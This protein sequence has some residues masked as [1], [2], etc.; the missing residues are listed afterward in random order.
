MKILHLENLA[1]VPAILAKAQ[2]ESGHSATVLETHRNPF[3]FPHDLEMYYGGHGILHDIKTIRG[4]SRACL[5]YDLVHVHG[6]INRKRLDVL[7]MHIIHRKPL[8]VHYHGSETRMGY[9]MAYRSLADA[10]IVS[11]PD[12][13]RWHNDAEFIPNPIE[14]VAPIRFDTEATPKVLHVSNNRALKGTDLIVE[15]MKELSS[16]GSNFEFELVENQSNKDVLERMSR[17]HILIDQVLPGTADLPSIIGMVSL[18]AMARGKAVVTTFDHEF[19]QHYP[20]CPAVAIDY[21]KSQ[22]KEAVRNLIADLDQA[23]RL[24]VLGR[25]YISDHHSPKVVCSRVQRVY[26]KVL[27]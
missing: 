10:K 4:V 8:V 11:R 26:E 7:G 22:L 1:G 3:N 20:G 5:G 15:A 18:E 19:R 23:N 12:L 16:E 21:G 13:L 2:L 27:G 24:G 9:G 25:E 14:P 17:S 6:G